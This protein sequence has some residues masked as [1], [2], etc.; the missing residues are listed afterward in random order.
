MPNK[1]D[2]LS[3]RFRK[4]RPIDHPAARYPGFRPAR[5]RLTKGSSVRPGAM[6]LPCDLVMHQD[7]AVPM[8]DGIRIYVDIFLPVDTKD[9]VPALVSWGPYGKQ[10][11]VIGFDDLPFRG[12]IPIESVSGLEM[13]EGPDPAYW[14][15]LGYAVINVDARGVFRS[16][17]DIHCWGRQEGRDGHDLVEWIA[18]QP[19]SNGKVGMTGT[20]WLAIVQWFVAAEQPPHLAAIAPCEGWSDLFRCDV[21]RGGIPDSGFND[22]ML[23][24]FAGGG[25]VE[26]VA[27]MVRA[28]P[29]MNDYWRDKIADLASIRVPTYAVGSWTN[30][31]HGIGTLNAW[32]GIASDRKW[33]RIHNSHE[34]KDYYTRVEDLRMFFDHFLKGIGNGW[35]TTPRVRMAILDPGGQDIVDRAEAEF[36]L[37]RTQ[38]RSLHLNAC[39]GTLDTA[40]PPQAET[41]EY[42][43]DHPTGRA[44]FSHTF[45][46]DTEIAGYIKLRLWVSPPCGRTNL[47]PATTKWTGISGRSRATIRHDGVHRRQG[48]AARFNAWRRSGTLDCR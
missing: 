15:A 31:I 33:L 40:N 44:R 32:R 22:H 43:A 7:V 38:Y 47:C 9:Q 27:A 6:P 12:G 21:V 35:E 26:D 4:T 11:G 41:L 37:A 16:E 42:D 3:L 30:A 46:T 29:T 25:G 24:M 19:W 28:D 10:G 1:A 5:K 48:H 20:S 2:A 36:P 8:R 45:E 23:S 13:F 39:T 17:G 14:C 34:W 18:G